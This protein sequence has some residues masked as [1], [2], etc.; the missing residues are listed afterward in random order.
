MSP[1]LVIYLGKQA[2]QTAALLAAPLLGAGLLAGIIV[3]IFQA[4]TQIHEMTLTFVP[5][6]IAVATALVIFTPWMLNLIV[7]FTS[8]LLMNLPNYIR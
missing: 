5:K 1:E 2:L 7:D 6:I 8:S 3:S 4:V